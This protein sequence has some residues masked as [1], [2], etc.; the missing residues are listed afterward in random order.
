MFQTEVTKYLDDHGVEYEIKEHS[1]P[2]LTC[3]TAAEQRSVR[4]EQIVKC[5]VGKDDKHNLYVM[6]IP[7]D[8][9]LKLK[10]VR[11]HVGGKPVQLVPPEKLAEEYG[12]TV[13]AIS[14]I[15]FMGKARILLDPTVLEEEYVD[16]SSGDPLAGVELKAEDLLLVTE[17]EQFDIIS[18]NRY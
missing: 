2:A 13:G 17:A 12:V 4:V 3:E 11:S 1:E 10:K 9:T 6:L 18:A 8:R 14:P 16:I 5:M 15:Q 7:G